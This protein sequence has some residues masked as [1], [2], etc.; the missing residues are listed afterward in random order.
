VAPREE[1][2]LVEQQP[3]KIQEDTWETLAR[4]EAEMKERIKQ[5]AP[6]FV[7]YGSKHRRIS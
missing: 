3:I 4:A 2:N 7:T 1:V 5:E 6:T